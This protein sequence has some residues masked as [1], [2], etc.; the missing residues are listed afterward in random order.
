MPATSARTSVAAVNFPQYKGWMRGPHRE[1]FES[2][3]PNVR[4][5]A[6]LRMKMEPDRDYT[7]ETAC[8]SCHSTGHGEGGGFLSES[9]T[10]QLAGVVCEACHG[11]GGGSG[12][13]EVMTVKNRHHRIEEMRER[14]LHFPVPKE[15]VFALSFQPS[16]E[17]GQQRSQNDLRLAGCF[18]EGQPSALSSAL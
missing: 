6:K 9:Q 12:Y 18:G 5:E 8:L 11:P 14:G 16:P 13:L 1:A 17:S 10:P 7:S 4:R 2:L 3:R 15:S